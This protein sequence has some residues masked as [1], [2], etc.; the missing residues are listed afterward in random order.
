MLS[1]EG[2]PIAFYSEKLTE[3][4]KTY[5]PYDRELHAVVQTL[6]CWRHYHVGTQFV[7]LFD[8]EAFKHLQSQQKLCSHLPGG[9]PIVKNC[10]FSFDTKPAKKIK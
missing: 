8:H 2:H 3:A 5:S 1:Q 4:K 10:L 9:A 6:R 7:F